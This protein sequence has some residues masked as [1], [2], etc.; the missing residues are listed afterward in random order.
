MGILYI[1]SQL[2]YANRRS[3]E[4]KNSNALFNHVFKLYKSEFQ[5]GEIEGI[6]PA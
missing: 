2:E 3:S 6:A 5:V 1:E 4:T